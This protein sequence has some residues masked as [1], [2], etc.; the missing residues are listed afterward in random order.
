LLTVLQLE[1][2]ASQVTEQQIASLGVVLA[3]PSPVMYSKNGAVRTKFNI[4]A[5]VSAPTSAHALPKN[6]IYK[7]PFMHCKLL[8]L[9]KHA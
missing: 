3:Q 5:H 7:L 4:Q 2:R 8:L 6:L 1:K 9:A